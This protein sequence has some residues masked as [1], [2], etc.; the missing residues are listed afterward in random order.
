MKNDWLVC[1]KV[2]CELQGIPMDSQ[3]V[4]HE[5]CMKENEE[6]TKLQLLKI[7][8]YLGYKEKFIPAIPASYLQ[9]PLP[10]LLV[11]GDHRYYVL[12]QATKEKALLYSPSEQR[13]VEKTLETL[14]ELQ[15][16]SVLLLKHKKA[17]QH[18]QKFGLKWFLPTFFKYRS[19]LLEVMLAIFFIQLLNLF[20]PIFIQVVIDKALSHN[21]LS[22]LT[23]LGSGLFIAFIFELL[24]GIAKNHFFPIPQIK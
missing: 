6:I 15:I 19:V 22:T 3:Q 23:V 21:S 17:K 24:L 13:P 12:V 2:I 10:A 8:K 18:N 4:F 16:E 5:L 1:L 9:L 7:V 14:Q 20:S 11:D